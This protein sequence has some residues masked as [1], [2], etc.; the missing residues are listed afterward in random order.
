M[1]EAF[2]CQVEAAL[3]DAVAE[4]HRRQ[5]AM[6][7]QLAQAQRQAAAAVAAAADS[8]ALASSL[9]A[10][11]AA[12]ADLVAAPCPVPSSNATPLL[13]AT[14]TTQPPAPPAASAAQAARV[15]FA[16]WAGL[17][18]AAGHPVNVGLADRHCAAAA[19]PLP[20]I[21]VKQQ[22][23]SERLRARSAASSPVADPSNDQADTAPPLPAKPSLKMQQPSEQVRAHQ[24]AAASA[25]AAAADTTAPDDC[26]PAPPSSPYASPAR[27][28]PPRAA[29]GCAQQAEAVNSTVS[30][31]SKPDRALPQHEAGACELAPGTPT[32]QKVAKVPGGGMY[33]GPEEYRPTV[34][35]PC[36]AQPGKASGKPSGGPGRA[37]VC[38]EAEALLERLQ[39]R[40]GDDGVCRMYGV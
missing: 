24:A 28:R 12:L 33:V 7:A 25:A 18:G 11:N 23:P 14:G 19:A 16:A 22:Q 2:A 6:G 38:G 37:A 35:G 31:N 5:A 3:A 8:H 1:P 20:K 4:A 15:S 30:C 36:A 32:R 29:D 10:E 26:P 17:P 27:Q 13:K 21:S 39:V 34:E 40:K 9:E